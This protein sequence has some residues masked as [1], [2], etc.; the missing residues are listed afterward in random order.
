MIHFE[1]FERIYIY[2]DEGDF[3]LDI[4]YLGRTAMSMVLII[5]FMWC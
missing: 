5:D 2:F 4:P 3:K 1:L